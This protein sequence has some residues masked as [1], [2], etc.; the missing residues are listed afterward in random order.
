MQLSFLT[1]PISTHMLSELS[2]PQLATAKIHA[3]W[4]PA[5]TMYQVVDVLQPGFLLRIHVR[6]TSVSVLFALSSADQTDFT[7]NSVVRIAPNNVVLNQ[8]AEKRSEGVEGFHIE[9]CFHEDLVFSRLG[10][11]EFGYV[12]F[13]LTNG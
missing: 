9:R 10:N 13:R 1:S 5:S 4:L 8:Q 12:S 7:T 11:S 3:I 2:L 6:H